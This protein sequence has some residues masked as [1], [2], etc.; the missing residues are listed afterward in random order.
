M[1]EWLPKEM[2]FTGLVAPQLRGFLLGVTTAR[3][4]PASNSKEEPIEIG[5]SS[6]PDAPVLLENGNTKGP[7]L[8]ERSAQ[9][10]NMLVHGADK[11][12]PTS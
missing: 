12:V 9:P 2:Q 5:S 7:T 10:K 1:R 11:P 3:P 6:D 4:T 8:D